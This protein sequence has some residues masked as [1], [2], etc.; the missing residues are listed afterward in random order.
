M[1]SVTSTGDM[2]TEA[3]KNRSRDDSLISQDYAGNN[4]VFVVGCPRSGTTFLQKLLESHPKLR[5]T[6]E[7]HLFDKY[8]GQDIRSWKDEIKAAATNAWFPGLSS[9]LGEDSF[10]SMIREYALNLIGPHISELK[11][12]ELFIEKTPQ[13]AE[14]LPE[15]MDLFPESKIVHILRDARDVVASI[16]AASASW[17]PYFPG[18]APKAARMWVR[19][20]DAV[21]SSKD[22]LHN[23]QFYQ[24]KYEDLVS[25]TKE[26]MESL[27]GFLGIKWENGALEAAIR[28]N[29][30]SSQIKKRGG[31]DSTKF[32]RKARPGSWKEDLSLKQK[33]DVWRIAHRTMNEVGY[34]WKYPW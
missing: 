8:L 30:A 11:S 26:S 19:Y 7:T 28:K 31:E 18:A 5:S 32:L 23:D 17:G 10:R 21:R 22:Q 29:D 14:Y 6:P 27:S 12:G 3:M 2:L 33:L 34:P 24:L 20:I 1:E 9:Y 4:I 15:I 13:H 16:L 25:S